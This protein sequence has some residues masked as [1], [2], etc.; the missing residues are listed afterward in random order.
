MD[1]TTLVSSIISIGNEIDVLWNMFA[2]IHIPFIAF[3][4]IYRD[5]LL[6]MSEIFVG[7]IAYVGFVWINGRALTNTY[8]LLDAF[9][10]QY[11][12]SF[13]AKERFIDDLYNTFVLTSYADRTNVVLTTHTGAVIIVFLSMISKHRYF[14]RKKYSKMG[15]TEIANAIVIFNDDESVQKL[16]GKLTIFHDKK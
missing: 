3:I 6:G 5:R 10:S 8:L 7:Y 16:S 13:G 1:E 2:A 4:V 14:Y 15:S 12:V 11:K 9:H